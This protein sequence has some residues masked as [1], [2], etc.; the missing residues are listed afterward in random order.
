MSIQPFFLSLWEVELKGVLGYYDEFDHVIEF[1]RRK[2]INTEVMIS[3]TIDLADI[4]EKGF[5]RLLA[6]RDDV[7][8]VVRP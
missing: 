6:S 3:D 1:L 5:R 8:I 7:K 2:W 4:E